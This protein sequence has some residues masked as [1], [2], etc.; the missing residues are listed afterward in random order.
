MIVS[1]ELFLDTLRKSRL[2]SDQILGQQLQTFRQTT[3]SRRDAKAFAEQLCRHR[4]LSVWQAQNLLAGKH[5]GYLLGSYELQG[6]LGQGGMSFVYF[7]RHRLLKRQCAVKVLPAAKAQNP[8]L[9][10]R[11]QREARAAASVD[12]PNVVRLLDGGQVTDGDATIHYLVMEYVA[13]TT[14]FDVVAQSGPLTVDRAVD[15]VRQAATGLAH[16]HQAGLVHRDIKPENLLLNGHGVVKLMDFGLSRFLNT[17]DE[18]LTIQH[19]GRVLGTA[20]YCAPEQAIDSHRVDHRADI[21]SLGCTLYF[22]LTGRPPFHEGSLAQRLLAH[23]QRE[24]APVERL[25]SDVPTSLGELLRRMMAKSPEQ[26]IQS[27]AEVARALERIAAELAATRGITGAANGVTRS[28]S[29]KAGG[30][31]AS[32]TSEVVNELGEAIGKVDSVER[33]VALLKSDRGKRPNENRQVATTLPERR[34]RHKR[35]RAAIVRRVGAGLGLCLAILIS[36]M[37][38]RPSPGAINRRIMPIVH[39]EADADAARLTPRRSSDTPRHPIASLAQ[40]PDG[41][42]F[43]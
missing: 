23:Q 9:L 2:L 10:A 4:R 13:G 42:S 17:S 21:Y 40:S 20:N 14:L 41:M 8:A 7:A 36:T 38:S 35:C 27:A 6:L 32:R 25:R 18:L 3:A 12:H 43:R 30:A 26:R 5:R 16:V 19:E 37:A 34:D 22:L 28:A 15:L 33:A 31:E 39:Q 11:F 24:P 1:L 29:P